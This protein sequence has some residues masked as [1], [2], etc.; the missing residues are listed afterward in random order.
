MNACLQEVDSR[1][2]PLSLFI[3]AL[4]RQLIREFPFLDCGGCAVYAAIL[5]EQ[6]EL[7]GAEDVSVWVSA[8]EDYIGLIDIDA[9]RDRIA[10][11][12]SIRAWGREGVE[13]VHLG[14]EYTWECETWHADSKKLER[15]DFDQDL[16]WLVY[17]GRLT[18]SETRKLS[19]QSKGWNPMFDRT[20]IPALEAS[21]REAF[22]RFKQHQRI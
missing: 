16:S 12:G 4:G 7:I 17:D 18:L 1:E 14:V 20:L 19:R 8:L 3:R 5:G 11:T 13:F 9:V 21:V 2:K 6:L 15:I 22:K 10:D